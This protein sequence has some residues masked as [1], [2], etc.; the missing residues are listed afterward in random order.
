MIMTWK[1][2]KER[3]GTMRII[4]YFITLLFLFTFSLSSNAQTMTVEFTATVGLVDDY[5]NALGNAIKSGD[6]ITGTYTID[7]AMIDQ[8]TSPEFAFYTSP[9]PLAPGLGFNLN[10]PNLSYVQTNNTTDLNVYI[11]D[12]PT[13]EHY[14]VVSCCSA[15][16]LSNGAVLEH[17][18]VDFVDP[19]GTTL[20]AAELHTDLATLNALPDKKLFLDGRGANGAYYH[21]EATV[22]QLALPGAICT[23]PNPVPTNSLEFTATVHY[24]ENPYSTMPVNIGDKISGR[25]TLNPATPDSDPSP[26]YA[27]Y[28]HQPYDPVVD[29]ELTLAGTTLAS[30]VSYDFNVYVK[31][32]DPGLG[33][34]NFSV[35]VWNNVLMDMPG[36]GTIQSINID[37]FDPEGVKLNSTAL[38][39]S[40]PTSIAGWDFHDVHIHG[41]DPNGQMFFIY[42]TIDA[43]NPDAGSTVP[44]SL[45]TIS[46]ASGVFIKQQHFNTAIILDPGMQPI[47]N[48]TAQISNNAVT[49]PVTDCVIG[50]ITLD[51]RQTV[52]C[53]NPVYQLAPGQNQFSIE[54]ELADGHILNNE[55]TWELLPY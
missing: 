37:F 17:I 22:T 4:H 29:I 36:G 55:A 54:V 33:D 1:D 23:A 31:N 34:D 24:I 9:S 26:E 41:I 47:V 35:G 40:N 13:F 44:A 52:I 10:L 16:S 2:N 7:T 48:H 3:R 28:Y 19:M 20:N 6:Q 14:T 8:D 30:Q 49:E 42:A 27:T 12:G 25:Y 21:V 45:L 38:L 51:N 43:I 39:E 50:P 18:M 53:D 46:P 32:S 11:Y 15:G 5:G